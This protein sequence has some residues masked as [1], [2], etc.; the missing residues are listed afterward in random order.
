MKLIS[1]I[2]TKRLEL[3]NELELNHDYIKSLWHFYSVYN[4]CLAITGIEDSKMEI[5]NNL[6]KKLI[7]SSIDGF[8]VSVYNKLLAHVKV[9]MDV[10][11]Q[12]I[13]L[14]EIKKEGD[15]TFGDYKKSGMIAISVYD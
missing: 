6:M 13:K 5:K 9:D 10:I 3:Y 4:I 15:A 11:N 1:E 7:S 12:A 2:I 14:I 8:N